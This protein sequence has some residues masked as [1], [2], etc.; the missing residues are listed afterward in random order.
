MSLK[1]FTLVKLKIFG[2]TVVLVDLYNC[3]KNKQKKQMFST[4]LKKDSMIS[5]LRSV[6]SEKAG[7]RSG[8]VVVNGINICQ[9]IC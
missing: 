3:S 2:F 4:F 6:C 7:Q 8:G 9:H 1:R 5:V